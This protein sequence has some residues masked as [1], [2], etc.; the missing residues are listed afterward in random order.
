MFHPLE[1]FILSFCSLI[2]IQI[3]GRYFY[4]SIILGLTTLTTT[5]AATTYTTTSVSTATTTT[6][7]ATTT[8]T[9]T[10][11]STEPGK[12]TDLLNTHYYLTTDIKFNCPASTH[13]LS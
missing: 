9:T 2:L 1:R 5:T 10:T 8:T 13:L 4:I 11:A 6:T 7:T 3:I 12:I